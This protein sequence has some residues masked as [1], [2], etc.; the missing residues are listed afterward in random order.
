LAATEA[1]VARTVAL[2]FF[3]NIEAAAIDEVCENLVR[4]LPRQRG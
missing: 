2:P 4:Q 3:N 1:E